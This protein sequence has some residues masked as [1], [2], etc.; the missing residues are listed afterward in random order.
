METTHGKTHSENGEGECWWSRIASPYPDANNVAPP[1]TNDEKEYRKRSL[2]R[3]NRRLLHALTAMAQPPLK[4]R[5]PQ[6]TGGAHGAGRRSTRSYG[7]IKGAGAALGLFFYK[8]TL[9][10]NGINTST[11]RY[12]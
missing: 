12:S 5:Q 9:C 1:A 4:R 2:S 3:C 6:T 7:L 11:S 10:A 8:K